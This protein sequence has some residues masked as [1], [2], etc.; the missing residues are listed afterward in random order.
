MYATGLMSS[1]VAKPPQL[2]PLK[3]TTV[4]C[5]RLVHH[6]CQIAFEQRDGHDKTTLLKCCLHYPKSPFAASKRSMLN[7]D[8]EQPI[9]LIFNKLP[10][11]SSSSSESLSSSDDSSDNSSNNGKKAAGKAATPVQ[12]RGLTGKDWAFQEKF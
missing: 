7:Y 2:Q 3:C 11:S 8:K 6:L 5:N 10:S 1:M 12:L 4:G 9:E